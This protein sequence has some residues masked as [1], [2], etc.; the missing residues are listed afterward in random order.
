MSGEMNVTDSGRT[1]AAVSADGDGVDIGEGADVG[2]CVG[3][4]VG[5]VT[6]GGVGFVVGRTGLDGLLQP[7]TTSTVA[8]LASHAGTLIPMPIERFLIP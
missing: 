2:V 8:V 5:R 3:V 7:D 1:D 4:G 6:N